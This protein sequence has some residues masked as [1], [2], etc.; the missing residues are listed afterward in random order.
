MKKIIIF[1]SSVF[2]KKEIEILKKIKVPAW[3]VASG[4]FNSNY[5]L[6]EMIK[7]RLPILLSTGMM[8]FKEILKMHRK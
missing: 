7:T 2:S 5:I 4:E 6:D 8:S 1:L 3:K